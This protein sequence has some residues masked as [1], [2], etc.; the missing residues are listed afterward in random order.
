MEVLAPGMLGASGSVAGPGAHGGGLR[1]AEGQGERTY[2]LLRLLD[3]LKDLYGERISVYLVE[4]YSLA[5]LARVVRYRPKTY[6]AFIVDGCDLIS[7][8][9]GAA[10]EARIS[11]R[12]GVPGGKG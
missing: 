4:P 12:L 8:M 6:P 7:G 1:Q 2:R 10:L 11:E 9:D 3:R 5:W